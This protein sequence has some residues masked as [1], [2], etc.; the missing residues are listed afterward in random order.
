NPATEAT[1]RYAEYQSSG[2]GGSGEKR[3]K[4]AKQLTDEEAKEYTMT[5]ILGNWNPPTKTYIVKPK[6][7][8]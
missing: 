8:K 7:T 1:A 4:W 6:S 3:V 2:P 5:K